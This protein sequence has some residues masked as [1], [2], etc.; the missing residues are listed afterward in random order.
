MLNGIREEWKREICSAHQKS[1]KWASRR[2]FKNL[3]VVQASRASFFS[4]MTNVIQK[5]GLSN[6]HEKSAL[7]IEPTHP[8][9]P[10]DLS[11]AIDKLRIS[12][13]LRT[14][15]K[16]SKLS[17]ISL[18]MMERYSPNSDA[19]RLRK[20][21]FRAPLYLLDPLYGF[22]FFQAKDG[23]HNHCFAID[24]WS[25][26]L[27]SMPMQLASALWK[28]RADNMLSG[29]ALAGR[30]LFKEMLPPELDPIKRSAAPEIYVNSESELLDLT[31]ELQV[32]ASKFPG[33]QLWF[34]GQ[35]KD[36]LTPDRTELTR[37][38]IA[39][40]S[41]IRDSD[42][43]PSLYRKYDL[44]LESIESFQSLT[45]ELA[46]WVHLAKLLIPT[47]AQGRAA[48]PIMGPAAVTN[49]GISSYQRGLLLQ[50]YGAP[51][52]YLDITSDP[53]VAAWFSVHSCSNNEDKKLIFQSYSWEDPDP[54][55]WP[56]IF[57]FP[58]VK[59][60]HPYLDLASIL[61]GSD[62]LRPERQKCGLLGGA[63]NLARNYCARYLGLKI[64]LRP[65]FR[66]SRPTPA[67]ELFPPA[68]ED[69]ALGFLKEQ[70]LGNPER[71]FIL[72]ELA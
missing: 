66:L 49:G 4:E 30:L 42:F 11:K 29:G 19:V 71:Q 51:S 3:G 27:K 70:G 28:N 41:N 62:A 32:C 25:D 72:S 58:L 50:Q 68:F 38:G 26:H 14:S 31:A 69:K 52:A 60:L 57:V 5:L 61:A 34:R 15:Y 54:A 16:Q 6:P 47:D 48:P 46:E 36:Y 24:I 7:S 37:L 59:G 13:L 2:A 18:A 65:G 1:Q 56:T 22:A 23:L 21:P 39:P 12:H 67:T 20:G 45:V 35:N 63:G 53:I 43:T 44:F 40:Y 9:S 17:L 10:G 55:C 64:R 33:V 8:V